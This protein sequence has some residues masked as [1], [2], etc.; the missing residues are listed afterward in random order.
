MPEGPEIRRQADQVAAAIAGRPARELFFAFDHLKPYAAELEGVKVSRVTSRGKAMLIFFAN[1]YTIYSHNQLYGRWMVRD[2][3][4]YPDT[5]RQLRLAIHNDAC[6]A[7]LYS[8]S[9]IEVLREGELDEHPFLRK[10]GP[11][12]LDEDL[13]AAQVAA[14]FRDDQ[15]RRRKLSTLLLDQGFLAGIGNYLRSEICFVAQVHPDLRPE[16]CTPEEIERLAEAALTLARRS[17]ETKGI[18]TDPEL[19]QT[20]EDQGAQWRDYRFWVFGREDKSC[21]VCGAPI[22]KDEL[23]GRRVYYCRDCQRSEP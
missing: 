20:L 17:Y 1:G 21:F 23:G 18:T 7:L 4:D 19:A 10:L 8:A 15:F 13:T 16:D 22:V 5:N 11:D 9:E 3:Y 2:A 6:S 14:R 12:V